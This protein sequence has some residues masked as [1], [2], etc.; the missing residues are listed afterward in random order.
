[1]NYQRPTDARP[2][3]LSLDE[4][5]KLFHELGH[6]LHALFTRIKYA[7]LN[8]VDR[9]FF[10]APSMMLEQFFWT[11]RHIKDVSLHY[12]HLDGHDMKEKWR[13]TLAAEQGGSDNI[14]E[15]PVQLG[16]DV[17]R[18]LA[19]ASQHKAVQGHLKELSSLPR[20]TC[21]STRLPRT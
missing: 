3:L 16:D 19:R 17:V 8:R 21:L 7:A 1:V 11:E 2:T 6:L 20:T 18:D 15:M 13:S 14:S 4:V 12:S 10:E 5:R 9:D